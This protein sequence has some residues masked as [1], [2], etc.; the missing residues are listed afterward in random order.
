MKKDHVTLP[1]KLDRIQRLS[2]RL[3]T[4]VLCLA[5]FMLQLVDPAQIANAL[6]AMFGVVIAVALSGYW[7]YQLDKELYEYAEDQDPV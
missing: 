7:C 4:T 3:F 1:D 2:L 5:A 6:T